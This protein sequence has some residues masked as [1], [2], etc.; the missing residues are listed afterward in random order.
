MLST[1]ITLLRSQH[2][3]R[4]IV[5]S[6]ILVICVLFLD[7]WVRIGLCAHYEMRYYSKYVKGEADDAD[8]ALVMD[9]TARDMA[10][11]GTFTLEAYANRL[12]ELEAA[13]SPDGPVNNYEHFTTLKA[14][15]GKLTDAQAA[16]KLAKEREDYWNMSLPQMFSQGLKERVDDMPFLY[17]LSLLLTLIALA[18]WLSELKAQA[19]RWHPLLGGAAPEESGAIDPHDLTRQVTRLSRGQR[20]LVAAWALAAGA[21]GHMGH[22]LGD[23][24]PM[25]GGFFCELWRWPLTLTQWLDGALYFYVGTVAGLVFCWFWR[26]FT[27][28]VRLR[29]MRRNA[30]LRNVVERLLNLPLYPI[31][32]VVSA[33]AALSVSNWAGIKFL[34]VNISGYAFTMV[35][36]L[37]FVWLCAWLAVTRLPSGVQMGMGFGKRLFELR[38]EVSSTLKPSESGITDF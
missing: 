31:Q 21:A 36:W 7:K 22:A 37:P 23:H 11:R 5:L 16:E 27:R 29:R 33:I 18:Y 15:I 30:K 24:G 26:L 32:W 35:L 10:K 17:C 4:R 25:H 2:P 3:L 34:P 8:L 38:L 13:T 14:Q 9:R 20:W 6:L 12:S 19:V 1:L 28:L